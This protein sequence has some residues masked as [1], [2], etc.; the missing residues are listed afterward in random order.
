[1]DVGITLCKVL[2]TEPWR[3][4]YMCWECGE[5]ILIKRSSR[6]KGERRQRTAEE[7]GDRCPREGDSSQAMSSAVIFS[8]RAERATKGFKPSINEA[9]GPMAASLTCKRDL[10]YVYFKEG[11]VA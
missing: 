5:D 6:C 2:K 11:A 4:G 3:S 8:R 9:C 7:G 10:L 1:M